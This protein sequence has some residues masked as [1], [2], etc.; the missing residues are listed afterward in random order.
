MKKFKFY[1]AIPVIVFMSIFSF[2]LFSS[3]K[4]DEK[5]D[6]INPKTIA[7]REAIN[8]LLLSVDSLKAKY[9][10]TQARGFWGNF[11]RGGAVGAAD[12]GGWVVGS[13]IGR[14]CGAAIGSAAG[15]GGTVIG[16]V[17][18]GK[19]GK[20]VGTFMAS[21]LANAICS[22]TS[23]RSLNPYSFQFTS[24]ITHNDSIGYYHNK[25]M[26]NL[27]ENKVRY[28]NLE[29]NINTSLM[30]DDIIQ[31][32]REIGKYD[33]ILEKTAVKNA[34]ISKIEELCMISKRSL[35]HSNYDKLIEEQCSFLKSDCKVSEDELSLYKK[36]NID[37]LY[38]TTIEPEYE[39][40]QYLEELS[41]LI[42]KSDLSLITKEELMQSIDLTV[43]SALCWKEN[44]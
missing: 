4:S 6:T 35:L 17:V 44:R 29:G 42:Q 36:I 39:L 10:Y 37:L 22:S 5:I 30:Y 26:Q 23:S 1:S 40:I 15:P 9:P 38:R 33:S 16:A 8:N 19:V 20:Y 7:K 14:W 43:N 34:I 32:L 2:S 25:M 21:G 24:I 28:F 18:G 11:F 13:T 41:D 3:C 27:V 31:Y 12:A